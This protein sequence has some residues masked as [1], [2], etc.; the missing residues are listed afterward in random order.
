MVFAQADF[1]SVHFLRD[2]IAVALKQ[3]FK[4]FRLV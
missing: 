3:P 1:V 4:T 2:K